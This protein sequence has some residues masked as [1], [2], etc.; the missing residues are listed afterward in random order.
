MKLARAA[1]M[2]FAV[3]DVA[4]TVLAVGHY[5]DRITVVTH[6]RPDIGLAFYA[7]GLAEFVLGRD[8]LTIAGAVWVFVLVAALT[9]TWRVLRPRRQAPVA[10]RRALVPSGRALVAGGRVLVSGGRAFVA[11]GRVLVSSG[12]VLREERPVLVIAG[13]LVTVRAVHYALTAPPSPI[14]DGLLNTRPIA[15]P[16]WTVAAVAVVV[17]AARLAAQLRERAPGPA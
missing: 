4:A 2:S 7:Y 1:L 8:V 3:V 10:G 15:Y 16:L 14:I 12:R 13:V 9:L 6:G 5:E 17:A 11:G